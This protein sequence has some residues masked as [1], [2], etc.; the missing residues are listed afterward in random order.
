MSAHDQSSVSSVKEFAPHAEAIYHTTFAARQRP[1][2]S[3]PSVPDARTFLK[4]E[5]LAQILRFKALTLPDLFCPFFEKAKKNGFLLPGDAL[6]WKGTGGC[7]I[8]F[9]DKKH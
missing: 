4:K 7:V 2:P 5:A 1:H 6:A 9:F 3:A 8:L